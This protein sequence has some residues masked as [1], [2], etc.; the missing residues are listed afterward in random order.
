MYNCHIPVWASR[1]EV[2]LMGLEVA[3]GQL[4]DEPDSFC[5]F[6]MWHTRPKLT[7]GGNMIHRSYPHPP[8]EI[9][10]VLL[11]VDNLGWPRCLMTETSPLND[12]DEDGGG[13]RGGSWARIGR[14]WLLCCM[15]PL[16]R[17]DGVGGGGGGGGEGGDLGGVFGES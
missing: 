15:K 7:V 14:L 12:V 13:G 17:P 2:F 11:E 6:E 5:L 3:Y 16:M 1:E 10:F 4:L 8:L 9:C